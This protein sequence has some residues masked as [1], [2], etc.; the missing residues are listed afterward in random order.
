MYKRSS[1]TI[2]IRVKGREAISDSHISL[3]PLVKVVVSGPKSGNL[4]I[5]S[6]DCGFQNKVLINRKRR[7]PSR[8]DT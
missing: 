1:T 2:C 3:T 4:I 7:L 8:C 6:V 5:A